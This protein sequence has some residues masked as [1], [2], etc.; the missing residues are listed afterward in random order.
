MAM[1]QPTPDIAVAPPPPATDLEQRLEETAAL[2]AAQTA[3]IT[4]LETMVEASLKAPPPAPITS[5]AQLM[6]LLWNLK[7]RADSG[8]PFV[9]EMDALREEVKSTE[10][11]THMERLAAHARSGVPSLT[12]L[13]EAFQH[14]IPAILRDA[15][16][17]P[18][19]AGAKEKLRYW[20]S[21]AVTIRRV[22][23]PSGEV[24]VDAAIAGIET[25][26]R[27]GNIEQAEKHAATLE[28]SGNNTVA[29]WLS[30]ARDT[31]EVRQAINGLREAFHALSAA[32]K[33]ENAP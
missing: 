17:L 24:S 2:V 8:Q 11:S 5:G 26:L 10:H 29:P 15:H 32:Q 30:Q 3:T 9:D 22:D 13:R 20:L 12:A 27:D 25:A 14:S 6:Y 33:T 4:K 7:D 31:L 21:H 18:A 1:L 19:D 23:V 28:K 16:P